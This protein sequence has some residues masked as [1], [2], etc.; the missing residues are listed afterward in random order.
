MRIFGDLPTPMT[1]VESIAVFVNERRIRLRRPA[2]A[3]AAVR[4]FDPALAE[5][6]EAGRAYLTDGRGV[7]C[8]GDAAL[9]DGAI[10]R[11]VRSARRPTEHHADA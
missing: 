3:L 11:V 10:L 5:A 9:Q 1:E 2:S 4:A 7:R 8:E 6:V